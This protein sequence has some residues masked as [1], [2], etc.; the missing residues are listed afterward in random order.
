MEAVF[1][2]LFTDHTEYRYKL[3]GESVVSV[4]GLPDNSLVKNHM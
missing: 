1:L 2:I 3:L 4:D